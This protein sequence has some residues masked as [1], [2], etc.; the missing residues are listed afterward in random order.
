MATASF[1][2]NRLLVLLIAW[3][4]CLMAL[5]AAAVEHSKAASPA[6]E[7]DEKTDNSQINS[8]P[9]NPH[10][11][12]SNSGQTPDVDRIKLGDSGL[13]IS[14]N[15][16]AVNLLT[17]TA[18]AQRFFEKLLGVRNNHGV[19]IGGMWIGDTNALISGGLEPGKWSWNSLLVLDLS[20]D[21]EKLFH[22]KGGLFGVEFLQFNGQSTNT[23]AGS[24]QGYNG[25][26][27]PD[28]LNR[29]ELYELWYRQELF[30]GKFVLRIGKSVPTFDFGNVLRPVP[31]QDENLFIPAVNGLIYTPIFV[32]PSMLGVIPGY[33]NSAYGITLNYA[34]TKNW[35]IS[36]GVYDGNLARGK[37]TGLAVLPEFNGY[38][39]NIGE[40]GGAWLIGKNQL[41]GSV[42]TGLWYQTG[43][44]EGPPGISENGAMGFY[45]FGSQRLWYKN[46][47]KDNSGV[48]GFFQFGLN[49]SE[50]L[51]IHRYFGVGFT[52]F[53]LVPK[54]PMDSVGVGM[55]L[56]W[57]NQN[58]FE[59]NSELMFQGFYQAHLI[60]GLYFQP[61]FTYIPTPGAGLNVGGA[62]T[63]TLRAIFLF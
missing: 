46:P 27:G 9:S 7:A 13:G 49:N 48:S 11:D 32:N 50:T 47:S 12:S 60:S 56:S 42:G 20:V 22:W 61:N 59:R 23:Q 1:S 57:L 43:Q 44:L 29:S 41:P 5:D 38:Y 14:A 15:P 26:P 19:R 58:I 21:T 16:G 52:G 24:I 2:A 45:I 4:A 51:P 3:L 36:Y 55:A 8:D 33:Y 10:D 35:Y 31:L 37:Q 17:G 30:D 6:A 34:P 18:E 62:W 25:L 28:P 40:T 53:G 63:S 54:R 39:F